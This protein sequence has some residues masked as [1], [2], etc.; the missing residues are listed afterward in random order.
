MNIVSRNYCSLS[1]RA[2]GILSSALLLKIVKCRIIESC[3][4]SSRFFFYKYFVECQ[5]K[6]VKGFFFCTNLFWSEVE[7]NCV[8]SLK[9]SSQPV[10]LGV[11]QDLGRTAACLSCVGD[12]FCNH[13]IFWKNVAEL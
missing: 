8:P 12:E 7:K 13:F 9:D 6:K 5:K 2:G 1:A 4:D 11:F 3:H 10:A